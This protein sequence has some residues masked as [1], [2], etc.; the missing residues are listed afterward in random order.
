METAIISIGYSMS[1]REVV[2]SEFDL[3]LAS[4][5]KV[6]IVS[7]CRVSHRTRNKCHQTLPL[8]FALSE[9]SMAKSWV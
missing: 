8:F 7:V 5:I 2:E 3:L 9:L 4:L 1:K 6:Y